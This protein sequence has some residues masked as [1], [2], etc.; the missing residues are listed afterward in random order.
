MLSDRYGPRWFAVCGLIL[1][2]PFVILLRLV[3]HDGVGQIV[4]LYAL[5]A[6]IG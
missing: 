3:T 6:L 4:L 1:T 5:L 2:T